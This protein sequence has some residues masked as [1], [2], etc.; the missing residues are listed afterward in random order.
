MNNMTANKTK[1]F[2]QRMRE[3]RPD[4][5][6]RQEKNARKRAIAIKLRDLRDARGMTQEDVAKAAKM[7]QST[8][9]RLE[10]LTGPIPQI[11]TIERY[12]AACEGHLALLIST[13]EIEAPDAA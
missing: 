5:V 2:R 7:T 11:E 3:T 1:G 8:I 4:V 13:E 12:V 6:E 9:A 10:A